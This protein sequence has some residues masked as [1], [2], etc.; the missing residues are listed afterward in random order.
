MLEGK[1]IYTW[2]GKDVREL[3]EEEKS[4]ARKYWETH[5]I[6][7]SNGC[8]RELRELLEPKKKIS[9]ASAAIYNACAGMLF[10]TKEAYEEAV[11]KAL[12]PIY[13]GD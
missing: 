3:T 11:R 9:R 6:N 2:F 7:L 8:Y 13:G 12:E 4:D 1:Y 5:P 10:D